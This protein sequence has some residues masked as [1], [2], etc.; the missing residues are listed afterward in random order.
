[1]RL[2][3]GHC[4]AATLLTACAAPARTR[5]PAPEPFR[6]EGY[7]ATYPTGL[8]LVAVRTAE[9]NRATVVASYGVGSADDPPGKEGLAALAVNLTRR[10]ITGRGGLSAAERLFAAGARDAVEIGRDAVEFRTVTRLV[11]LDEV[12]AVEADRLREPLAGLTDEDF[13]R[14]RDGLA[15]RLELARAVDAGG[16]EA[17]RA[18]ALAH[19]LARTRYGGAPATPES[20]RAL[21]FADVRGWVAAHLVPRRGIVVVT[22]PQAPADV[23][24]RVLAA[25]GALAAI[26]APGEP[27]IAPEVRPAAQAPTR[28]GSEG[29]GG[30]AATLRVV[31][32]R[33]G[34]WLGWRLPGDASGTTASALA[35]RAIVARAVAERVAEKDL[36]KKVRRAEVLLARGLDASALLVHADLADA[37]AAPSVEGALRAAVARDPDEVLRWKRAWDDLAAAIGTG[38]FSSLERG[39]TADAASLVRAGASDPLGVVRQQ[40][41]EQVGPHQAD[42]HLAHLGAA[43]ARTLTVAPAAEPVEEPVAP[44]EG[45]WISAL[46]ALAV[47]APGPDAVR[48][49]VEPPGLAKAVRHRLAN[50]LEVVIVPRGTLPVVEAQ[51]LV[52]TSPLDGPGGAAVPYLALLF[53]RQGWS[54]AGAWVCPASRFGVEGNG[55]RFEERGPAVEL[56][57]MLDRLAC[58][59]HR[60]VHDEVVEGWADAARGGKLQALPEDVKGAFA[61]LDA[62]FP[63]AQHSPLAPEAA[64]AAERSAARWMADNLRP[65]RAALVLV[66][67]VDAS[68]A[69][70][71]GL[72]KRFGKWKAGAPPAP[73]MAMPLPVAR[74][75]LAVDLPRARRA[76]VGVAVRSLEAPPVDD[77]P[78]RVL[79]ELLRVRLAAAL[80]PLGADAVVAPA[81]RGDASLFTVWIVADAARAAEALRRALAVLTAAAERAPAAADTDLARW[82]AA[83][84]EAYR[85]DTAR[86]TVTAVAASWLARAA[87]ETWDTL[88]ERLAATRP[89]D[90]HVAARGLALGHEVVVVTGDASALVPALTAAGFAVERVAEDAARKGKTP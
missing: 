9:V 75:V 66:G 20:V 24:R 72:E 11:R 64:G 5:S 56:P 40:A 14:E 48:E 49:L 32:A 73:V 89:E 34:V 68:P 18:A 54:A 23:A 62:A 30:S 33:P 2:L 38:G 26:G 19:V 74:R 78:R 50:G 43:A 63:G 51:L 58:W 52:R 79:V 90:V 41:T 57:G 55:V 70:L 71:A 87:P 42:Y 36:R 44:R 60:A 81:R 15:A 3:A 12:L 85:F 13:L 35:A 82:I 8:R 39:I 61:L 69:L 31:G 10:A 77:A 17:A 6:Y 88:P 29:E 16:A 47:A 86:G 25:F 67:K 76:V 84:E 21:T 83:R 59:T 65:E 28:G 22:G 45:E 80:V 27:R 53:S 46:P 4:L 7:A 1:M 37:A